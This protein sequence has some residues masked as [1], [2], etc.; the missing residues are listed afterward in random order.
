MMQT[1]GLHRRIKMQLDIE[2]GV[3]VGVPHVYS[4]HY[5]E[6]PPGMAID[7]IV[8]HNISLPPNE[9]GGPY[10]GH[11]FTNTL[12]PACHPYFNG[13]ASLKVSCHCFIRR[14]GELIQYVPFH[15]RAWHAGVS[16]FDGRDNCND[17]S[18]GIELEGADNIL[19]TDVQY[20]VLAKLVC[21]LQRTYP[22]I[23]EDR[24]VG[25]SDVAPGRKTDPGSAF[26]WNRLTGLVMVENQSHSNKTWV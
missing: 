12:D 2:K 26:D 20:R 14:D 4:P 9:F 13:I 1:F 11:F 18:V 23:T 17:F 8:V 10:V 21:V 19:Y 24:V 6:R 16:C 15:K 25:H 22:G 7:L 3:L 5:N